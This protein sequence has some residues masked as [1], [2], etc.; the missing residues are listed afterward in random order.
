MC[1]RLYLFD[2]NSC[3]SVTLNSL[4]AMHG[5]TA[6]SV[7]IIREEP[8]L[9]TSSASSYLSFCPPTFEIQLIDETQV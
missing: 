8:F 6:Q 2:T 7:V 3:G 4:I 5:V 1:S 9:L